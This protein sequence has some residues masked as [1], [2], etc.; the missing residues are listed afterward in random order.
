M[1]HTQQSLIA[2][3]DLGKRDARALALRDRRRVRAEVVFEAT[4]AD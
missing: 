1:G 2:K 4:P 3:C